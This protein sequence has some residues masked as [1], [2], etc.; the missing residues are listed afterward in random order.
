MDI[1]NVG[2]QTDVLVL[3]GDICTAVNVDEQRQFFEDHARRFPHVIYLMGNHEHYHGNFQSSLDVIRAFLGDIPDLH[4]LEKQAVEIDGVMFWGATLW[5]DCNRGDEATRVELQASMSDYHV[6]ENGAS[7]RW[8]WTGL[9]PEDTIADHHR[10]RMSL[11][12]FLRQ[13]KDRKVVVCTHHAPTKR[14]L[15]PRYPGDI[16]I[17]G[18]YSSDLSAIMEQY[19]NIVL[20]THGHTHA[21]YDYRQHHTRVVA[22]PPGYQMQPGKVQNAAF[23]PAKVIEI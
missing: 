17:N 10:A 9:T 15:H 7:K 4:I 12:E 19:P 8:G 3:S 13:N 1:P 2:G 16:L 5:T 20:W 18:G 22:N 23:D 14:S 11:L 21:S 6:I